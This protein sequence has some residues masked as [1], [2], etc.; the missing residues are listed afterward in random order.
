MMSHYT[1]QTGSGDVVSVLI[2]QGVAFSLLFVPLTTVALSSIE[3][4]KLADA[5][6]LNSLIRQIGGSV[7]LAIFATLLSRYITTARASL[8]SHVI[9]GRPE[10]TARLSM[11]ARAMQRGGSDPTTARQQATRVLNGLVT[12]QATVLSFEKLFLLAGILFLSSCR[13]SSS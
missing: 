1:L 12:G 10:V 4:H 11:I 6:G 13:C 9:A 8:A 2:I 3:R 7:G 5:T